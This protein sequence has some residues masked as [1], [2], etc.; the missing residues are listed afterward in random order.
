MV[1]IFRQTP[2]HGV[3]LVTSHLAVD[4]RFEIAELY[5][6]LSQYVKKSGKLKKYL[7]DED[8]GHT[9]HDNIEH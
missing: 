8:H 7:G 1:D 6:N 5:E 9:L 3:Y 4:G 2:I